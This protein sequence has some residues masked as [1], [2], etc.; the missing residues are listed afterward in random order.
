MVGGEG[1]ALR[2][3]GGSWGCTRRC[4][5]APRLQPSL[6]LPGIS[7]SP[8]DPSRAP[9]SAPGPLS[10]RRPPSR[11]APLLLL[12]PPPPA[13]AAVA[14]PEPHKGR[15]AAAACPCVCPPVC[16]CVCPRPL[17]PPAGCWRSAPPAACFALP[18]TCC[19]RQGSPA[20]GRPEPAAAAGPA[21]ARRTLWCIWRWAP[22]TSRW[23]GSCWR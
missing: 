19:R 5:P 2:A 11:P 15:G 18:G 17:C 6:P 7:F 22:T 21:P 9:R 13:G 1:A 3:A 23:D 10:P 4:P 8:L 12:P 20:Y 14:A 16:P